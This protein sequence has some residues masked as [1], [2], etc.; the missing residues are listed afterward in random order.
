MK[1]LDEKGLL[2][3]EG[4]AIF[5]KIGRNTSCECPDHLV[6]LLEAAEKFTQ[7]QKNCIN[8]KPQDVYIHDWLQASSKNLEHIISSMIVS[9]ARMEGLVDHENNFTGTD[10]L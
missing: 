7:Y 4:K 1:I 2:T 8:E 9:L 3:E 10:E 6:T 5:K